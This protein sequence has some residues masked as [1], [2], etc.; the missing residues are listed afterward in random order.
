MPEITALIGVY[1]ADG[2]VRGELAY[3][4]GA[5]LGRA[6]CD[7]CAITHGLVR[8]K[9]EWRRCRE[10]LPV[11]FRAHHRDD[12]PADVLASGGR[13][14]FV[15]AET[16]DGLRPLLDRDALAA[17]A[18]S[19]EALVAALGRAADEAGLSWGVGGSAGPG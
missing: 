13:P 4:V 6:H 17:C 7:L 5:R 10:S 9:A 14:S 12:A 18:G 11:P 19:P 2:T 8:P 15:V 3:L 16:T 1:D